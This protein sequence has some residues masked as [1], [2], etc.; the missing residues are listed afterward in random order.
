MNLCNSFQNDGAK[1]GFE[2]ATLARQGGQS[3]GEHLVVP[4]V[5]HYFAITTCLGGLDVESIRS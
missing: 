4:P 3:F 2:V 5:T 1:C